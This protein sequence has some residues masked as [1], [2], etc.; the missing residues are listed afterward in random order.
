M[1]GEKQE[2]GPISGIRS[3]RID[4]AE[5]SRVRVDITA[6]LKRAKAS[7]DGPVGQWV[8]IRLVSTYDG[9]TLYINGEVYAE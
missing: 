8:D 9:A 6:W 1:S 2:R 5:A 4:G 3:F 7:E